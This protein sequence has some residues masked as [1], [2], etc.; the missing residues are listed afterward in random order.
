MDPSFDTKLNR[1]L[2][3][4]RFKLHYKEE[5]EIVLKKFEDAFTEKA[6]NLRGKVV[7][8]HVVIDVS[9]KEEH[10]WSPQ[11]QLELENLEDQSLLI[12]GLF[13]PKPQLWT[14]FMFIHFGVAL[15]FAI[16]VTMLYTDL[17]LKKDHTLSL[18]LTIAMP[19][20]WVLFYLFGRWGKK[21]GH[22]QMVELDDFMNKILNS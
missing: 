1:I 20:V 17:S 11:L 21:K 15:A 5:K 19:I 13:G 22:R 9:Q 18:I 6:N 10:F 4:P 16:F 14:L 2:L 7:G 8:D 3:K 12:K